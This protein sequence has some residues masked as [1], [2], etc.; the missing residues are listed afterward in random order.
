VGAAE[1]PDTSSAPPFM[2]E[3][4]PDP[5]TSVEQRLH[6]D[7]PI[8]CLGASA[9]GVAA[10]LEFFRNATPAGM[11]YVVILHLSPDHESHLAEV[12]QQATTMPVENIV[13]GMPIRPDHIYTIV[14]NHSL[15]I[16]DGSLRVGSV[17]TPEE[18]RAPIDVFFRELAET[19]GPLAIAVLLSGTGANGSMGLKRIKEMGGICLVQQP[20]EAE[21]DDIPRNA[22]ATRL[23]DFVLPVAKIHSRILDYVRQLPRRL[24]Q[25]S[26]PSQVEEV[27]RSLR[28]IFSQ[29]R[30]RTGHDFTN[31]KRGTVLRR[32]ERRLHVHQ[33][34]TLQEYAQLLTDQP[35]ETKA[36]L[37]DLLISVTNFFRDRPAFEYVERNIIP[38][39]FEGKNP[40][41]S[42]RVWIVGCATGEEAYSLAMLLQE[43][44]VD[45]VNPIPVQIFATD[46]DEQAIAKARDGFYTDTDVA[47]VPPERLRR[48]F[49]KEPDG[50]RV[51]KEMREMVL[52]AQHNAINDPPFSRLDLV[53]CRN[54]MIYLNPTAQSRLL[55]VLHFALKPGGFLFLGGSESIDG[56]GSLFINSDKEHRLYQ[57]R[58]VETRVALPLT[59]V[60]AYRAPRNW[61]PAVEPPAT[62]QRVSLLELHQRLLELYAPPSVVIN[63]DYDILHSSES[64]AKYLQFSAGEPSRNLLKVVRPELRLELRTALFRATKERIDVDLPDQWV[65]FEDMTEVVRIRI[66][67][68]LDEGAN[69]FL[70]LLFEAVMPSVEPPKATSL[71]PAYEHAESIA[72]QIEEELFRTRAQLRATI[73]QYEVQ[74]EEL[75]ASNEELQ[76]MNEEMRSATEE[77]ETSKEELQSVNEE[78]ST[79]NQELKNKIEE[80]SQASNHARN[81]MNSTDIATVF[82]DRGLRVRFF[83]P[84]A[85]DLF[86]LIP[87]DTGRALLDI[88]H[89]LDYEDLSATSNW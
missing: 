80:L 36:L 67:H 6:N 72:R 16:R 88:T 60:S 55:E 45:R 51:R 52:F 33:L 66:R 3:A 71:D 43:Y 20:Q 9:G 84:R 41:E 5:I 7:F 42:V 63:E 38:R 40:K 24:P 76:A 64:A 44:A 86:N 39:L 74:T 62:M 29:L 30:V 69:G 21:Y 4:N 32:L 13:D 1:L 10:L 37:R 73:E 85:R 48:F 15:H 83:T 14:P 27:E 59:D 54:L 12:L 49:I 25:E 57:S 53:S 35:D 47:D 34:A 23:V 81:L 68:S 28:E 11:A 65:K 75:K 18:R 31:Y 61:Q 22:I 19:R 17:N 78:L 2:D 56:A 70:L 87:S 89:R 58:S 46:I 77:L 82:L 79:V 26:I 50:Y 8:V